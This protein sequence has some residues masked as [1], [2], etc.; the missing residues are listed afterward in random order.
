MRRSMALLSAGIFMI[1]LSLAINRMKHFIY[2]NVKEKSYWIAWQRSN[3]NWNVQLI[4][5]VKD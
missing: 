3:M 2:Q 1:I 4:N 5:T